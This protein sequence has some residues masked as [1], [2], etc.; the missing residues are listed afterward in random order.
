MKKSDYIKLIVAI[1]TGI[2]MLLWALT[3]VVHAL[4]ATFI[5]PLRVLV[6]ACGLGLFLVARN[7]S[8]SA[9]RKK[10]GDKKQ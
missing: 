9:P 7:G 3:E 4:P 8:N 6:L 2:V 5:V 1:A 10:G